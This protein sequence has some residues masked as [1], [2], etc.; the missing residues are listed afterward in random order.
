MNEAEIWKQI[1][2]FFVK[3]FDTEKNPPVE[4]LLF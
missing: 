4:I 2:E 3:N 1:E